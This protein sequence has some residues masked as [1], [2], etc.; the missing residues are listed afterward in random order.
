MRGRD[1]EVI[2]DIVPLYNVDVSVKC[3]KPEKVILVPQNEEIDFIY[4]D[5]K[6]S[7]TVPK[8]E[9]HQMVSI[10]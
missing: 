5:G 9:I 3:G 2:E 8:V 10:E 7:F 1:T 6:T 4:A